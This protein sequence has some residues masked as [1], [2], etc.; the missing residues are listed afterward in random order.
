MLHS[1]N[2]EDDIF[3]QILMKIQ[4][5]L[6]QNTWGKPLFITKGMECRVLLCFS[7]NTLSPASL[8]P[9]KKKKR[10]HLVIFWLKV[11]FSSTYNC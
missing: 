11:G 4:G 3:L 10:W 7:F 2:I 8:L 9:K 6:Q 5:I 1:R